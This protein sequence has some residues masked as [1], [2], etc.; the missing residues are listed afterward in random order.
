MRPVPTW[1]GARDSTPCPP[2]VRLRILD[3]HDGKCAVC[4][5][6]IIGSFAVDHVIALINGG[7]NSEANAQPICT[8]C[9]RV[10]TAED[11]ADKAKV[12][13]VRRKAHGAKYS[14]RG[15]RG[16][17]SFSGEIRWKKDKP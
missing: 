4:G 10:K 11:V 7:E 12:A 3:A 2:R 8:P 13:A 1:K 5:T 17:R 9:H 6:K 15:F 16:W 14:R